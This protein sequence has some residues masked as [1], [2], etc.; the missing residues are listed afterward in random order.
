MFK[1]E[2]A[3][4]HRVLFEEE[5]IELV[6]HRARQHV[7]DYIQQDWERESREDKWCRLACNYASE[8]TQP[9]LAFKYGN[10]KWFKCFYVRDLLPALPGHRLFIDQARSWA[11]FVARSL[12]IRCAAYELLSDYQKEQ[13]DRRWPAKQGYYGGDDSNALP[14]DA[15]PKRRFSIRYS[16]AAADKL[17]SEIGALSFCA[18]ERLNKAEV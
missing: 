16:A 14:T 4:G 11:R 6:R 1:L 13:I 18:A 2:E 17:A 9:M 12:G 3:L 10:G 7:P 8:T 15:K 5:M